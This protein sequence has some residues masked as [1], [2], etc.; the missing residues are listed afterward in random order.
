MLVDGSSVFPPDL[1]NFRG[2]SQDQSS[3]VLLFN[4]LQTDSCGNNLNAESA[5][6]QGDVG[7]H[8]NK[9]LI[10][11]SCT[12]LCPLWTIASGMAFAQEI[13]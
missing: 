1:G 2:G 12:S 7:I 4:K 13:Q 11:V 9:L 6:L 10:D 3:F 8:M 5:L